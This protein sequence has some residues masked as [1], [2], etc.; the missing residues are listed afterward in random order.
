MD[1][2]KFLEVFGVAETNKIEFIKDLVNELSI[3]N[4]NGEDF[5]MLDIS[6]M[7]Y[8]RTTMMNNWIPQ[9]NKEHWNIRRIQGSLTYKVENK[10]LMEFIQS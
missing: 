7:K 2:C 5:A 4:E 1:V 10:K 8:N 9:M 3:A 6:K